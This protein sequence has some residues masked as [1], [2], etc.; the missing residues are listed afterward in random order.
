MAVGAT[1]NEDVVRPT[2]EG[3]LLQARAAAK[4]SASRQRVVQVEL[5]SFAVLA[6]ITYSR[7][8]LGLNFPG[9]EFEEVRPAPVETV[10][11]PPRTDLR[12]LAT[13]IGVPFATLRTLNRVLVRGVTPPDRPWQLRVPPGSAETVATALSPRRGTPKVRV[14]ASR[15]KTAAAAAAGIHI[16]RPRDTV[17][18]IAKR[19]G[20]SVGDV[21]RWNRLEHQARIR[22][23]DRLRVA[24]RPAVEPDGQGGFR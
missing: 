5:C 4:P 19:Y 1:S 8:K 16:V 12:R 22:P 17:S 21:L 10:K 24:T 9:F 13:K 18:S 23:G 11:V 2:E 7:S 3:E 14:A 6:F 15:D 20:V